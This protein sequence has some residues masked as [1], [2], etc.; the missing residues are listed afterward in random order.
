M[1]SASLVSSVVTPAIG[2]Q[3]SATE[4]TLMAELPSGRRSFFIRLPPFASSRHW[5][6][7]RFSLHQVGLPAWYAQQSDGQISWL[8][9][10]KPSAARSDE[11]DIRSS[12]SSRIIRTKRG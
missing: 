3:P 4:E 11:P 2:Q 6:N 1:L 12:I 7:M 10:S 5:R 9:P 8:G